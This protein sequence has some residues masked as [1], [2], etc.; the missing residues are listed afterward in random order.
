MPVAE[1][2]VGNRT[3][4]ATDV[5]IAYDLWDLRESSKEWNGVV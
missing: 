5:I 4:Y 3:E 2:V 1:V